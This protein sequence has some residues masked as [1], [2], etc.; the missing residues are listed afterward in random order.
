MIK[1]EIGGCKRCHGTNAASFKLK[2]D[3]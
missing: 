2:D 1:A 3:N